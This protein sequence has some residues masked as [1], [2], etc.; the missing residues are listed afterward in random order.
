MSGATELQATHKTEQL[1]DDT[2][3]NVDVAE[4][5]ST[6]AYQIRPKLEE[7]FKPLSAKEVIHNVLFDHLSTK[8]YN[9]HEAQKWSKEIADIIRDKIK[10]MELA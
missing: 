1:Q 6:Q 7:K 5:D 4:A 2:I 3:E 9:K 10:K 8:E